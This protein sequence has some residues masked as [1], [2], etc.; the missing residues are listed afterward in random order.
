MVE[1]VHN[2]VVVDI[3]TLLKY[4]SVGMKVDDPI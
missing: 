2:K 3:D 4:P 1:V